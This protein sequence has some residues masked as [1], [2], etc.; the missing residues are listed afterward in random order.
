LFL[1]SVTLTSTTGGNLLLTLED[2]GY[3]GGPAALQ[4]KSYVT[5]GGLDAPAGSIVTVR[6]WVSQSNYVPSLGADTAGVQGL[7]A[8]GATEGAGID[9]Q[10]TVAQVFNPGDV[11]GGS[12]NPV[13]F[14]NGGPYSLFT[15]VLINLAGPT[16]LS[17]NQV[18]KVEASQELGTPEPASLMLISTAL[19][20]LGARR[21]FKLG[22]NS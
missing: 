18:S 14:T 3:T 7:S 22:R 20:G 15:Q 16:T 19:L 2:T 13:Y 5:D 17:F 9:S 12:S 6:S 1:N 4:L 21:R 10:G 11:F 8:M